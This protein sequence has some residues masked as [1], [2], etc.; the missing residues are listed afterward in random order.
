M[1]IQKL[2]KADL[3][4]LVALRQNAER[5]AG[6]KPEAEK[7]KVLDEAYAWRYDNIYDVAERH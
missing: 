2:S 5:I 6:Q 1:H 4:L 7:P 3:E